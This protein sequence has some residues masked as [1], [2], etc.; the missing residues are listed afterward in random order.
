[1][2]YLKW[3][4]KYKLNITEL[5]I[6][7]SILVDMISECHQSMKGLQSDEEIGG[8]IQKLLDYSAEHFE[9]EEKYL[10]HADF[11]E[12]ER[13]RREHEK[14][15]LT[16]KEFETS[17]KNGESPSMHKIMNFLMDW[18]TSHILD[19]DKRFEDPPTEE[20]TSH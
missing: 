12:I 20:D 7:N 8:L 18:L 6:Q 3:E 4:P 19:I 9:L 11:Y 13:H 14:F 15:I 16:V 2:A 10:Q 5:D 17:H 1:M